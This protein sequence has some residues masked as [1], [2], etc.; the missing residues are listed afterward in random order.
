MTV[1]L[2]GETPEGMTRDWMTEQRCD[3]AR[4]V[5]KARQIVGEPF[6][7]T[8]CLP[9]QGSKQ[10]GENLGEA[11]GLDWI[12]GHRRRRRRRRR[13]SPRGATP[14]S[15]VKAWPWSRAATKKTWRRPR[16]PRTPSCR[17]LLSKTPSNY[18]SRSAC[19]ACLTRRTKR[20]CIPQ[21]CCGYVPVF[22][23]RCTAT[24]GADAISAS[25]IH[26]AVAQAF[27]RQEESA[28]IIHADRDG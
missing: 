1:G 24:A 2:A 13:Q 21:F 7:S 27:C 11:F 19:I 16:P 4:D 20:K 10:T 15:L 9:L 25:G 12:P 28:W 22:R 3:G 26:R 23:R 14:K 8:V 18:F 5:G 6:C 17:S